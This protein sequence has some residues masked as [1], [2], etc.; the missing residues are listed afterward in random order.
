MGRAS[1]DL[2]LDLLGDGLVAGRER[3]E[4]G[5]VL[6]GRDVTLLDLGR[7]NDVLALLLGL[8]LGVED[9]LDVVLNVVDCEEERAASA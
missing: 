5:L 4:L 9:G 3:G 2:V 6:G 8:V 1:A 7:L